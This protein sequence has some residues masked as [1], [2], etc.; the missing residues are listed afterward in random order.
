MLQQEQMFLIVPCDKNLGPA[1]IER[2][3]YLKIAMRD[4]LSDTTTY[5]SLST[6][7]IDR[8]SSEINKNILDWLKTYNKKLTKM[9]RAFIREEVKSNQSPFARFN[10]T[11]KAHKLKPG[12]TVDQL[13]SRLIVSCPGSLLHGLSVWVDR[14]VQKVA[15]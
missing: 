13:K 5:K 1:I 3:D 11:L 14:K 8:Y 7:D 6:G 15:Q 9:E 10:L 12:Q 4:H 2:Q